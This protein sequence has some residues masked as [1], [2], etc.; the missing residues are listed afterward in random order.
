MNMYSYLRDAWKRPDEGFVREENSKRMIKWRKQPTVTRVK[1]PLRINRARALG[2]KAKQGF[3]VVRVKVRRGTLRKSRP[4]SGRKPAGL[5]VNKI[6]PGKNLRWIAEQRAQKR[7]PNLEVLN[8]YWVGE[9]G[10]KKYY[11]V[12]L[13]DPY[14]PV[15]KNDKNI[16]WICNT[17]H[18]GRVYR[19]LTSAG[20]K[21]RGLRHKGIGA[22]KIRPSL[23][24]NKR[25]AK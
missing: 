24:A 4:R 18:K 16:N 8:S 14:H 3:I 6:T 19:G 7:Y 13:V 11:E 2:Y 1:K 5:G 9:D 15:I 21:A 20:K 12:I 23:N 10:R 17:T 22:E 25:R